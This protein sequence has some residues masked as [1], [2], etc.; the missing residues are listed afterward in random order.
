MDQGNHRKSGALGFPGRS[1]AVTYTQETMLPAVQMYLKCGFRP[2]LTGTVPDERARWERTFHRLG[3]PELM[4]A[5]R[6]DYDLVAKDKRNNSA[7]GLAQVA[8]AE[9]SPVQHPE[10]GP[11]A[12]LRSL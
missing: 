10:Q 5:A 12:A 8:E 6:D 4:S 9:R 2:L 11:G 1:D 3:R 7:I